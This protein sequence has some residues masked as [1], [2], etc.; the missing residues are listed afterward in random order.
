MPR[1]VKAAESTERS[2]DAPSKP[3]TV[4][5]VF[6]TEPD[7]RYEGDKLVIWFTDPPGA[8]VQLTEATVFTKGMAEW[9]VGPGFSALH[10]RFARGTELRMLLD[11]RPMTAREPAA[12]PVIMSA[13]TRH[14]F[15]FAKLGVIA[16]AKP[17]PLYMITLHS[18]IALLSAIGPEIRIFETIDGALQT[19]GLQAATSQ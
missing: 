6:T 8:V 16:P 14:M 15:M 10:E 1:D 12:R 11:L 9:M 3:L 5:R 19:L 2:E 4:E 13:A 18:A 17:P 7:L